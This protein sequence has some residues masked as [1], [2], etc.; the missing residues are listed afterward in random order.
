VA[1]TKKYTLVGL[2]SGTSLDGLDI[3]VCDFYKKRNSWQY[4]IQA[5]TTVP[6]SS[7]F[8]KELNALMKANALDFVEQD[9]AFG[10][11][12]GAE[13]RK[14]LAKN[15]LRADAIASHGHTIF[16]QPAKGF[17]T[18]IGSGAHIAAASG[19]PTI[20]DF[21][22]TDVALG[23]QGAPLVPIGDQLLFGEYTYCLNLGGI[24]NLSFDKRGK[25]IAGDIGPANIPLNYLATQLGK[26]YDAGG[27]IAAKGHI[28][29]K[30]LDKLNRLN[31]YKRKFPKSLGREW[32]DAEFIPL[33]EA[34]NCSIENKLCTLVEHIAIQ[35]SAAI[36]KP[37]TLL[38]TGGGAL[39][40][41]LIK[42]FR[43]NLKAKKV[44]ILLPDENTIQ[45]KE[46]LIFAFL[47]LKRLLLE[48][49]TLASV[50]GAK[51]DSIGGAIYL[52]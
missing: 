40:E 8:K 12:C 13:V 52:P 50:T 32:V 10:H 23:G 5:A 51:K 11:F 48:T 39:N 46:A 30:L 27:K 37:G 2:M 17:T 49:N 14:F 28:E 31:F 44:K 35:L 19:L 6:Y 42:R 25:R 7:S 15:K 1:S 4:S 24:A 45:Y 29:P 47:G 21:R 9:A 16:H 33:L 26:A 41:F 38:V 36:Q 3:A 22:S 18:Q 34:Y 43:E 20:C